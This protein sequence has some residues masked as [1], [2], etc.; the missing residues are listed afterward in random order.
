MPSSFLYYIIY[1]AVLFLYACSGKDGKDKAEVEPPV[2]IYKKEKDSARQKQAPIINIVDS[3]TPRLLVLYMKDSASS[4]RR[5]GEK[6]AVIYHK[7]LKAVMT[8]NKL[9]QAGPR[10]AW[11]R[12]SSP[13]FYF[14]AGI[15]VNKKPGKLPKKIFTKNVGGDSAVIAHYY[16]P[17]D[18]T[19]YAYEALREW[20][21]DNRKKTSSPPYEVYVTEPYDEEGKFIDPFKVRTDIVFPHR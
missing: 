11:Y 6:L 21:K 17:Y 4:S 3:V 16:G 8:E 14:E 12:S 13:P 20:M 19:F 10:M 9:V 2:V 5:I 15:P 1:A 18:L 7:K